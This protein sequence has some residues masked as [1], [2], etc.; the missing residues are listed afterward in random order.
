MSGLLGGLGGDTGLLAAGAAAVF[1]LYTAATMAA[2]GGRKRRSLHSKFDE[3]RSP[4][5]VLYIRLTILVLVTFLISLIFSCRRS[6]CSSINPF[7]S[8]HSR[9]ISKLLWCLRVP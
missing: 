6:L 9:V 3:K 4:S 5:K 8:L 2:A 1:L 7:W